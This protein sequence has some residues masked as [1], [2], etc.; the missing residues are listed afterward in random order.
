MCVHISCGKTVRV[1]VHHFQPCETSFVYKVPKIFF[2][3]CKHSSYI[4]YYHAP[5]PRFSLGTRLLLFT[6]LLTT[7]GKHGEFPGNGPRSMRPFELRT[8]D[9]ISEIPL[10]DI[11][12]VVATDCSLLNFDRWLLV[13]LEGLSDW[14]RAP[15]FNFWVSVTLQIA[16]ACRITMK[17]CVVPERRHCAVKSF[18]R[19]NP[20]VEL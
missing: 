16:T 5:R 14:A 20:T 18:G 3:S 12:F 11:P 7:F 4:N 9:R 1:N 13:V 10:L 8:L 15:T 17:P 6:N 19:N 2:V